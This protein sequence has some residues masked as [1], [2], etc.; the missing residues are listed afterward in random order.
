[1][2]TNQT[3]QKSLESVLLDF[4]IDSGEAPR[5]AVLESYCKT[6]P[7]FARELT[8]YALAWLVDEA[9]A[10]SEPVAEAAAHESSPLVSRAIS[11]MYDRIREREDAKET[12]AREPGATAGNPFQA[13]PYPRKRALCGQLGID[14]PLLAKFQNRLIDPDSV[15]RAF[16]ERFAQSLGD[17]TESFLSHLRM[18]C[19]AN[20]AADFKAEGKPAVGPEKQRFEDAV[21]A[22]SLDE[23]SKQ[24][25]LKE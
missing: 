24:V 18:P 5:P 17:T 20:A 25:L 19:M 22:S 3:T 7:Q 11:R 23:Q 2:K 21:R 13:L 6:Y 10:T 1:M 15:P 16:L 12:V 4:H 8:D 14:M 9:L